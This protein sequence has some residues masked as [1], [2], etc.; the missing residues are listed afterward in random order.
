M[1]KIILGMSILM[2]ILLSACCNDKKPPHRAIYSKTSGYGMQYHIVLYEPTSGGATHSIKC[3]S[4][5]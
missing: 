2:M 1:K 5:N 4:W 3:Q